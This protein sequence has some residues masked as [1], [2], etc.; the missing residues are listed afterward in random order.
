MSLE[1]YA[2]LLQTTGRGPKALKKKARARALRAKHA[3]E[4]ATK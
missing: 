1:S 4:T 2:N 3:K